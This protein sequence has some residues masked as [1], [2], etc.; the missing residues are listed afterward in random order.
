[1]EYTI[2]A[3]TLLGIPE[4]LKRF[5]VDP[6]PVFAQAGIPINAVHTPNMLICYQRYTKLLNLSAKLTHRPDFT[7]LLSKK[8][9]FSMLGAIGFA[10]KEAP[11]IRT[12]ILDL[13]EF[14]HVNAIATT[15]EEKDGL[16]IW[17]L[18]V[19]IPTALDYRQHLTLCISVATGMMRRFI[20]PK[21][22][23]ELVH[24]EFKTPK[25]TAPFSKFFNCPVSFNQEIN[26]LIFDV[27]LLDKKI[28]EP[29]QQLYRIL[30]EYLEQRVQKNA[31]N[32]INEV[33]TKIITDLQKGGCSLDSISSALSMKTR[34]FQRK[35]KTNGY[36]FSD[37]LE[38]TRID[39][40]KRYLHL[41]DISLTQ[42]S[43]MLGYSEQATFSRSFK[44]NTGK[45][46]SQ[47]RTE[48][49][50]HI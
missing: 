35:L 1:M 5:S 32:F 49:T 48:H 44:R 9:G 14:L 43:D 41:S 26:A 12:A 40:A 19:V 46:P 33:R 22:H 34:T 31:N 16:A 38:Q 11:D 24:F 8:Q 10:I 15:L 6:T 21:W 42:I 2:R 28:P 13:C 7:I 3:G 25:N 45:S 17:S 29:N 30:H 50:K 18:N 47:W 4:L 37:L 39:M 23:P 36:H 20:G 27:A